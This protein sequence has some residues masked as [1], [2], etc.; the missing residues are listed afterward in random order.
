LLG[1]LK[2]TLDGQP[3]PPLPLRAQGLLG[4]LLLRPNLQRRERLA[5]VL[6]PDVSERRGRQ[7]LSHT[8]WEL[9]Q[10]LP[11]LTVEATVETL[12]LSTESVWLDVV[13]FEQ[14]AAQ[15]DLAFW[16]SALAL[17][18]G[19][20]LEG[21]Y[22]DW[23]LVE[24]EA[25]YLEYVR[26]AHRVCEALWQRGELE[27]LLPLAEQLSQREPFDE[28][29]LRR[30]MNVYR[31][32]GRRGAALAA[33]DR[34]VTLASAELG[35]EPEPATQALMQAIRSST[36]PFCPP[37][38]NAEDQPPQILLQRARE[39]LA[40]AE[41]ACVEEDLERLGA[42]PDLSRESRLLA[43]DLALRFG[44]LDR[45]EEI[46]TRM[47]DG[48]AAEALRAAQLALAQHDAKTAQDRASHVVMLARE[49]KEPGTAMGALLTLAKSHQQ[50][51]KSAQ[52]IRIAERAL[53]L[54]RESGAHQA[55]A[56]ALTQLGYSQFYQGRYTR[57]RTLFYHAR[58][59]ALEHGYRYDLA[60]ALRGLRSALS[61]INALDEALATGEEE[62]RIWRDLGLEK[63]EATALEGL[64]TIQNHLGRS[65]DSLRT[66][67]QA[68]EISKELGDP[69]RTA[70]NRYNLAYSLLYH[71][72]ALAP[73]ALEEAQAA[74]ATFQVHQQPGWE[75]ATMTAVGYALWVDGQHEA[76]LDYFQQAY[77]TSER[78]GELAYLPELLAYRGLAHLG[79]G[80][81]S[82]G[83]RLTSRAMLAI[84]QEEISD[85]V[86][87]EIA[88]AHAMALSA[89]GRVVEADRTLVQ[90][91]ECLLA[92]AA[93]LENAEARQAYF[94]RN[95]TMRRLMRELRARGVAPPRG[96]GVCR[97]RLPAVRGGLVLVHW[98]VD[99]GPADTTL[100]KSQGAIALRRARLARLMKE[101]Q[102]QGAIPSTA[103][104]AAALEVSQR[105]IQRDLAALRQ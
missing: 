4:V 85:E 63:E 41:R 3:V 62:L 10:W 53:I 57:A 73:R 22:D 77:A 47:A 39:A 82:Q 87:P 93:S 79:L 38:R 94:H 90:A 60:L 45:A 25:L 55:M 32:V 75:A 8:L 65:A 96:A 6:F 68:G 101:A 27:E 18:R 76:A 49:E 7:R 98:T 43:F 92:G 61:N 28:R 19:D 91:Y 46:L 42:H 78:I 88:Y 12:H 83:L 56:Q 95:P 11:A 40:R 74:L 70:I 67:T 66:M 100:E 23:L 33:Y 20:L 50:Q 1:D 99:A 31:S 72:A 24:R 5:G 2:T 15:D 81:P 80:Q 89:N 21:L 105:T 104:L 36:V 13:A 29:A 59:V 102:D 51:G 86:I 34:F 54:A 9:R 16:Q 14:A 97:A 30:L 35:V 58:A 84:A 17:Y 103:D 71:D 37:A 64:A 26:L 44:E 48:G 52:A 69:M